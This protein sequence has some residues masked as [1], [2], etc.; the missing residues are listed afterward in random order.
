MASRQKT[1]LVNS[2]QLAASLT[3]GSNENE[4]HLAEISIVIHLRVI[5]I[6]SLE[7]LLVLQTEHEDNSIDP[8]C[9]LER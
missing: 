7:A 5:L 2:L 8:M 4:R 3:L 1:R 6:D 9:E